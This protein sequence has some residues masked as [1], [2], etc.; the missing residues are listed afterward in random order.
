MNYEK[1]Y[2]LIKEQSEIFDKSQNCKVGQTWDYH[3]FPVIKNACMLADKYGAN[4]DVVEVAALFHDYA[5]LIDFDN[6][7]NHHIIGAN[8]AEEIL[9][10]DGFSKD[11]V[12]KVKACIINHRASVVKEK[13]SIEEVCVADAD[14]MSHLDS[15]IE[16]VCWRAYLGEDI[17]TCN[18]FVK[19]KIQKSYAKMSDE[20]K[21]LTKSQYESILRVLL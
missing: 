14:A 15:F 4:K 3:L 20:T 8:L 1:Y 5:D 11:F 9:L 19:N 16:L 21:E 10:S 2:K 18:N 7:A 12:E 6:R 17:M 13:F